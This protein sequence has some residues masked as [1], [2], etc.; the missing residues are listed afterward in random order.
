MTSGDSRVPMV[1]VPG[2]WHG[3][4]CW[5]RVLEGLSSDRRT[6]A[7][8]LLGQGLYARV[9]ATVHTRPFDP[10]AFASERSPIAD[11][12]LDDSAAL[13]VDQIRTFAADRPVALVAHSFGGVV[14]TRVVEQIP[15]MIGHVAYVAAM[16]PTDGCSGIEILDAPEQ[17][18][19]LLAA[20]LVGDPLV[21]GA[22]RIDTGSET[23]RKQLREA[24]YQDVEPG[25]V[26]TA[27]SLLSTD[28]PLGTAVGTTTATENG[29][30]SVPRTYVRCRHDRSILLGMQ[31]RLIREADERFP[32]NPTRVVTLDTGHSPFLA[33]P[34]ALTRVLRDLT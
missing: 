26:E 11:V 2:F 17:E 5:S 32:A 8:D 7:V 23:T 6:L 9:P 10:A 20:A 12:T 28:A 14:A 30:G 21:I 31:D 15:E 16:M 4:W 29:W 22:S 34:A 24:L 1:F 19:E 3:A 13:L 33:D 27:I 18:G 25:T